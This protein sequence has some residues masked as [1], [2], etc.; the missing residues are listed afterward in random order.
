MLPKQFLPLLPNIDS[1]WDQG[2]VHQKLLD[3]DLDSSFLEVSYRRSNVPSPALS[4]PPRPCHQVIHDHA[5]I[6]ST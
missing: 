5:F 3:C 6:E 1:P 4:L 2:Q